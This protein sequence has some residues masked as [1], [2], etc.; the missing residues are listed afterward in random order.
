M[1]HHRFTAKRKLAWP[2]NCW[3]RQT[4]RV[5]ADGT[6]RSTV[7]RRVHRA[8]GGSLEREE[9]DDRRLIKIKNHAKT[10]SPVSNKRRPGCVECSR[11]GL[12]TGRTDTHLSLL[13]FLIT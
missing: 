1:I 6:Q 2:S 10:L 7:V 13:S 5:I 9:L 8:G 4:D 12:E 11:N 3:F